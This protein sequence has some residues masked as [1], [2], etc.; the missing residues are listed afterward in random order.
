MWSFRSSTGWVKNDQQNPNVKDTNFNE[1]FTFRDTN[2]I[3]I[4][5]RFLEHEVLLQTLIVVQ[6]RQ[7]LLYS[8]IISD[9]RRSKIEYNWDHID[10]N[11]LLSLSISKNNS[12]QMV[13]T[14]LQHTRTF[15]LDI[16]TGRSSTW[17]KTEPT[18]DAG[19]EIEDLEGS[20]TWIVSITSDWFDLL[21]SWRI[22]ITLKEN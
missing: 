15:G 14:S 4:D 10:V 19:S 9:L 13:A 8:T 12:H 11:D 3:T 1:H 6:K 18:T 20:P 22:H 7:S 16:N 21:A 2:T 17:N 5:G